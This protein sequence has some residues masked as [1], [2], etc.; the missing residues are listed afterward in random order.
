MLGEL[1]TLVDPGGP[2]P[3]QIQALTGITTSMLIGAPRIEE[4]LPT[5]LEFARGA[6]LVAHNAPFDLG[7]L[8]AAAAATGYDWPEATVVDTVRLARRVVPRDEAPDHRLS[9]LAR[10]FHAGTTP[11]HRALADA[12]ATVDVLHAL[13]GRLAPVGV[14][15]LADLATAA[16]RVPDEVRRRRHLADTLEDRP[17]VYLMRGADDEVLHVGT[18]TDLRA[19]VRT[20]FTAAHRRSRTREMVRLVERV[21]TIVCGTPLEAQVRARRLTAEHRPRYDRR[22]GSPARPPWVRL[23][24]GPGARL[25]V[26]REVRTG[27]THVGPFRGRADAQQAAD[28]LAHTLESVRTVGAAGAR[29]TSAAAQDDPAGTQTDLAA[30][31]DPA[32]AVRAAMTGDPAA[33]VDAHIALADDLRRHGREIEAE[34]V[35]HRLAVFLRGAARSQRLAALVACGRVCAARRTAVGGWEVVL[36]QHGRLTG[37]ATVPPGTHPGRAIDALRAAAGAGPV[38]GPVPPAPACHPDEADLVADWLG[39]PGTRLV[40]ADAPWCW[41]VRSALSHPAAGRGM[42][43][44]C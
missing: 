43:G 16:D 27:G 18:A 42:M 25:S 3:A 38:P 12:R 9:T 2:V 11:E 31:P 15:H 36:V 26:V 13:L 24:D 4:V 19:Q 7:F 17:G 23:S 41:P 22:P 21:E 35:E 6:V 10:L 29:A 30:V 37:S 8:Q 20:Y 28:A 34:A 32:A 14:T 40:E 33:V 39:Q 5:F 1:Q 44:A